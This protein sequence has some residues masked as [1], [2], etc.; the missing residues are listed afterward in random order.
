MMILIAVKFLLPAAYR[1][2]V[3][4]HA[5]ENVL[6]GYLGVNKTYHCITKYFFLARV[7]VVNSKV[8]QNLW[9]IPELW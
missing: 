2:Q 8:L 6:A 7:R 9:G 3:L 1:P 5:H 4:K